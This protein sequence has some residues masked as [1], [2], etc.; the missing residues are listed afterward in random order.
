MIDQ[1]TELRQ[2]AR[3]QTDLAV[4]PACATRPSMIAV[5]GGKGGV[6][7]TTV[8]IHLALALARLADHVLL[9]DADPD[10]SDVAACCGLTAENDL[11]DLSV[12][13]QPL[14]AVAVAGPGGIRVVSGAARAA[15]D[16]V[17]TERFHERW[18]A[19]TRDAAESFDHVVVDTGN[20]SSRSVKTI[21]EAAE[22]VLLVTTPETPSILDTYAS[23]KTL[24][25]RDAPPPIYVLVNQVSEPAVAHDVYGRIARAT[26]R[27]LGFHLRSAGYLA[28]GPVTAESAGGLTRDFDQLAQTVRAALKESVRRR[29]IEL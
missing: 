5:T 29:L 21:W 11:A 10:R 4:E 20:G 13:Q 6:G 2:L 18:M 15:G 14:D 8:A 24:A 22:L 12:G 28:A 7:T 27:F 3:R 9:V 25:D 23:I 1:A 17:S 16:D 26:W 19:A